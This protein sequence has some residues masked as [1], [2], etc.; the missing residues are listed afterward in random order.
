MI[1]QVRTVW[2]DYLRP[3]LRRP[4]KIQIAALCHRD[5][6]GVREIILIT[7]RGTGRW[8]LPKGWPIDGMDG[9]GS[10]MQEAWEEAGVKTGTTADAPIASYT[11]DKGLPG[12]WSIPVLTM[13]YPVAVETLS[14]SYPEVDERQRIWVSP[15][16]AAT[17]V[18]EPELQEILASF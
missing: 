7:S 17:M 16:T 8:I 4:K 11:Y 1:H 6:E 18:D 10:A 3:M 9:A 5:V 15:K 14:D 2:G 12:G 13:V